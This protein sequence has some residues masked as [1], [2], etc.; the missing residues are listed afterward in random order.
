MKINYDEHEILEMLDSTLLR[1][2]ATAE[3]II[4]LCETAKANDFAAVIVNPVFV[5]RSRQLLK[6][7][8]VKVGT[9]VGFPFGA[10]FGA[11]K[12][13]EAKAAIK[14]GA[15][16]LDI[17]MPVYLAKQGQWEDLYKELRKVVK[18]CKK[19]TVKIIIETCYLTKEEIIK[20]CEVCVKLKVRFVKTSTGYGSAGASADD[21]VLMVKA[22]KSAV[23]EASQGGTDKDLHTIEV[24]AS[25]GI[26][27]LTDAVAMAHAGAKRI[28]TTAAYAISAEA[29]SFAAAVKAEADNLVMNDEPEVVV[30]PEVT[31]EGE[32]VADFD[33]ENVVTDNQDKE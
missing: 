7:S 12:V 4:S 25:G 3:D 17:V 23:R 13:A 2:D 6:G 26:R 5:K 21:V 28:G 22:I 11:V 14:A 16:D 29:Q 19:R 1:A 10:D 15:Q 33:M 20:A 8:P 18:A 9:V 32:A 27:T 31:A 30:E 24:K